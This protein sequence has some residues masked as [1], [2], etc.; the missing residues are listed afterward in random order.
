MIYVSAYSKYDKQR[1]WEIL[2]KR[3]FR[4]WN[5]VGYSNALDSWPYIRID[6]NKREFM[7]CYMPNEATSVSVTK[8]DDVLINLPVEYSI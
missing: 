1:A 8:L 7:G 3:H 5:Q 4:H 2:R 6:P